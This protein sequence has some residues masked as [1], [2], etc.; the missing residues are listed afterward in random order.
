MTLFLHNPRAEFNATVD[1]PIEVSVA[2]DIEENQQ[3][4]MIGNEHL[5]R[6][7]IRE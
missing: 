5:E 1:A 6:H 3:S 7:E 2:N 4:K